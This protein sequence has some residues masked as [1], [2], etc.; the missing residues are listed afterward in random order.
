[1]RS[2]TKIALGLICLF[3]VAVALYLYLPAFRAPS[4]AAATKPRAAAAPTPVQTIT[5]QRGTIQRQT[6]ATGDILAA[7]RVEVFSKVEGRLQ[8]LRVEQGDTVHA[9]QIIARIDDAELEARVAK[10]D[11]ELDAL[12]ADWAQMQAGALPEE[13]AQA[14]DR[15]QQTEAELA[16]AKRLLERTQAMVKRGLQSTQ[17]LED[18]ALRVTQARAAHGIAEK[19]L[20]LLRAGARA[21]DRLA[22]QARLRAAQASLRLARAELRNAVITAPIT[23]IVSHRHVDPG[24]YITDRTSIVTIVD[25]DSVKIEVPISERDIGG[26]RPGLGARIRVDA[27]PEAVFE[28][29]VRRISP[30]IDPASRSGEVEI[31]VGNPDYRLKPGMFAK[32]TI[33]LEQRHNVVVIPRDALHPNGTGP[34]VFV[35]QDGTAH[36]R[37]VTTG[38]Q[39][40]TEVEI[41]DALEPGAEIVLA[42]QHSLKD[43]A[44]VK[45]VQTKE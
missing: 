41:V 23:G 45:V 21:E 2:W 18:A 39:N 5:V 44:P 19:R 12:R 1:M 3:I 25:M 35:V 36:L 11:A 31:V 27:Y 20:K 32:V 38:L 14:E 28:G 16:N 24:A 9:S 42:G 22:L 33:V 40:D 34:A 43:K 26:L 13:I 29:T 8:E 17:E 30:T 37:P 10:A 7:V 6:Q 4:P 15:L